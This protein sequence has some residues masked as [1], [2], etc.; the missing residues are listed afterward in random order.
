MYFSLFIF[1][2][3]KGRGAEIVSKGTNHVKRYHVMSK[4]GQSRNRERAKYM[5]LENK[6]Y[7]H[8]DILRVIYGR[9]FF[10]SCVIYRGSLSNI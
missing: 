5:F 4:I 9:V 8:L 7:M 2:V 3:E 10:C 1:Y 6:K